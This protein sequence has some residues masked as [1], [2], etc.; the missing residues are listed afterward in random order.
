[1][2]YKTWWGGGGRGSFLY[3]FIY[4]PYFL[5][6]DISKHKKTGFQILSLVQPPYSFP[7]WFSILLLKNYF[8]F[9]FILE[10]EKSLRLLDTFTLFSRS[11]VRFT[12][13]ASYQQ[14]NCKQKNS[15]NSI[16][17]IKYISFILC[18]FFFTTEP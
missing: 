8:F 6:L 11:L 14:E 17:G 4:Y 3:F 13:I 16:L 15:R 12:Q 9:H 2:I 7:I 10:V 5:N 18:F 1:M